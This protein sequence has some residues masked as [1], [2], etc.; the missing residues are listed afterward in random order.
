M[1]CILCLFLNF[2]FLKNIVI[3]YV[4]LKSSIF[5]CL[6]RAILICDSIGALFL[7]LDFSVRPKDLA[8]PK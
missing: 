7:F 8:A 6:W 2:L 3:I 5:L 4:Y 1:L